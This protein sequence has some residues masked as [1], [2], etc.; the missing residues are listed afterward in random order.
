MANSQ[1]KLNQSGEAPSTIAGF[2]VTYSD[3]KLVLVVGTAVA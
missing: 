2:E 3:L 1:E